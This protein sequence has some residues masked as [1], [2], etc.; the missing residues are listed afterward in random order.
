MQKG[1]KVYI[2]LAFI[3][4]VILIIISLI[5]S[6]EYM[7]KEE[8][9]CLAERSQLFVSSTCGHCATQKQT[10]QNNLDEYDMN[11]SIFDMIVCNENN[12]TIKICQ[13]N[14]ITG[15]PTWIINDQTYRGVQTLKELK[16][17]SGC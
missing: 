7:S 8:L 14:G 10:L 5:R 9:L 15:V 17:L 12:Q 11:L 4:I 2:G 16:K 3:V 13:D 1:T 6:N